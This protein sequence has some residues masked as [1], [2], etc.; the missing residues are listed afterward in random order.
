MM[1]CENACQLRQ[2]FLVQDGDVLILDLEDA[3][4][5]AA[6]AQARTNAIEALRAKPQGP[7]RALRINGLD[8][9]DGIVAN[10]VSQSAQLGAEM[11]RAAGLQ[12]ELR[13]V[14]ST[15]YQDLAKAKQ[16]VK[17]RE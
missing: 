4:A 15:D 1:F 9:P 17:D 14:L 8:T 11:C 3:V 12:V 13:V 16:L 10:E 6:K 2:P 5:P 7:A